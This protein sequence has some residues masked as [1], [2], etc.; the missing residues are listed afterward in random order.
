ME[1]KLTLRL[2]DQVIKRAKN[3]ARVHQISLSK[4]IEFYL[5]G[6]TKPLDRED[7]AFFTPL[8]ESLIGVLDLPEGFDHK[9]AYRNYLE[10]KHQ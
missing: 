9:E 2:N 3:Y 10:G 7:H 6:L 5:D 1:T 4:M 8:V